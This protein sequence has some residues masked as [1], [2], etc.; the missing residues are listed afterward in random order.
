MTSY[1]S[2]AGLELKEKYDELSLEELLKK[3]TEHNIN[4]TDLS[5]D[6]IIINIIKKED[7]ISKMRVNNQVSSSAIGYFDADNKMSKTPCRLTYFSKHNFDNYQKGF[8]FL[9]KIDKLYKELSMLIK[10]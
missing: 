4:S 6:D 2:P 8:P 9:E 7:G 5:K 3:C 1:L 10:K